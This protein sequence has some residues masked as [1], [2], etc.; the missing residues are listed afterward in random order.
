MTEHQDAVIV[1]AHSEV[2]SPFDVEHFW[3]ETSSRFD[4]L[5]GNAHPR[6]DQREVVARRLRRHQLRERGDQFGVSHRSLLPRN[7]GPRPR[8]GV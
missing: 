1:A 5:G 4:H 3:G 8:R 6:M 7:Y 2:R